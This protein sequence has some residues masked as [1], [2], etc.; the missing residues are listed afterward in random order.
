MNRPLS[1]PIDRKDHKLGPSDANLQIVTYSD[2]ECSHC[3]ESYLVIKNIL[4]NFPKQVR[5]VFRH[6]PLIE[7]HPFALDAGVAAEAAALQSKFW[8]M[9]D[10]LFENP[11]LLTV[12]GIF[13]MAAMA[14]LDVDQFKKDIQLEDLEEKVE[15]D[16]E[17]G[18]LSS[19][20][21][22]P[23]FFINNERFEGNADQLLKM[24]EIKFGKT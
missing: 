2:F 4:N 12:D 3:K 9:H 7:I 14:N 16:F 13:E 22:T 8:E 5:Y 17:S 23:T 1:K 20:N 10:V 11:Q 24:L 21:G 18:I 6:F 15:L 19:V